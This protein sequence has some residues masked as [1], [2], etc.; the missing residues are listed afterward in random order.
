VKKRSLVFVGAAVVGAVVMALGGC[1]SVAFYWQG[2][3]GQFDLWKRSE[4]IDNLIADPSTDETLKQK[5]RLVRSI[6]EFATTELSLPDNG[7]YRTYADVGKAYVAWNVFAAPEFSL[8]SKHWCFP[9]AGCVSYRGYFNQGDAEAE[10]ARLRAEGY[11]VTLG[12]VPAYSTLG[13][14]DDPVLNT[15]VR[16]PDS[17]VARLIFHE[18][19]HQAVYVKGDSMFNESFAVSVEEEG[20]RRWLKEH[21]TP[22]QAA[23]FERMQLRRAGFRDI[24]T[25]CR[26]KLDALYH[27]DIPVTRMREEK[28]KIFADM[29]ADYAKMREGW[30][31]WN[32]YDRWFAQGLNN[33]KIVSVGLYNE[34]VPAFT[35]LLHEVRG[36]LQAYYDKVQTIAARPHDERGEI[37]ARYGSTQ[38]AQP[39]TGEKTTSPGVLPLHSVGASSSPRPQAE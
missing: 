39:A 37:L 9:V 5:L 7:S 22:E 14:F 34:L 21:G 28:A 38:I 19:A 31:G 23:A 26:R 1:S 11:D 6:R 27:K 16:S 8:E 4:P 18:L 13:Y 33:A 15:F 32:G 3:A 36:N 29:Q 2:A 35:G 10:A 24:V 30:G 12:G 20:V 25:T 17:E